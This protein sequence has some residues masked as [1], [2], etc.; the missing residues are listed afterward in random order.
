[1]ANE[2]QKQLS[3]VTGGKNASGGGWDNKR[4]SGLLLR[5]GIIGAGAWFFTQY[6]LPFLLKMV[7]GTAQLMVGAVIVGFLGYLIFNPKFRRFIRY[8]TEAIAQWLLGWVIEMNPF[9][10]L[11]IKIDEARKDREQLRIQGA[12]LKGQQ[13]SLAEQILLCSMGLI[14]QLKIK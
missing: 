4:I 1:M 6:L 5:L 3:T 14:L 7:W 10:I 13:D 9:N 12:K 2:L 11:Q 8:S